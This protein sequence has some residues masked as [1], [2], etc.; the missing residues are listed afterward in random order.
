MIK[1]MTGYGRAQE[2]TQTK[3]ITVEIKSVNHRYF[4]FGVKLPRAYGF[5]EERLKGLVQESISRGKVDVF[6][7][8]NIL[9]G[10]HTEIALNTSLMES[11]LHALRRISQE[12]QVVN[13]ISVS[14]I[15][16]F[17]D[18]FNVIR[19]EE[20]IEQLWAEVLPVAQRAIEMFCRMR[21]LEGEQLCADMQARVQ[22]IAHLSDFIEKESEKS[23]L[24][25]RDKLEG[26]IRDIIRDVPIDENRLLTEVAIMAD[27]LSVDEE[28]VRLRS[29]IKQFE[30][31]LMAKEPIGRKMDFLIQEMNREINTIG[32]KSNSIDIARAVVDAKADIEKIREQVQNI[33]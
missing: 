30:Q 16:R 12:Y 9:E 25:Y 20:D 7:T 4:D 18:I 32:S 29:H 2:S 10:P 26:R 1:S 21:S 14:T 28:V 24:E 22:H 6:V 33:E 23:I 13:D 5:L 3:E 11:Y 8:I 27:K 15:S 19:T 31:M 17:T